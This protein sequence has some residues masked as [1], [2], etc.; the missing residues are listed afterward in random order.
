MG[1]APAP[2]TA[3]GYI[4]VPSIVVVTRVRLEQAES[5]TLGT[6]SYFTFFG[7]ETK[8]NCLTLNYEFASTAAI[9]HR[10]KTV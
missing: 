10:S 7:S 2:S 3:A 6:L 5:S 1:P 9:L 4:A 8:T